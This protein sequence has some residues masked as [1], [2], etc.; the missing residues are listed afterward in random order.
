MT[1]EVGLGQ[2]VLSGARSPQEQA[3][4][5]SLD[6]LGLQV[7]RDNVL[8]VRNA[9]KTEFDRLRRLMAL[10]APMLRVGECGPDPVSGPAALLFNDK[11]QALTGQCTGYVEA[12]GDA[13][14]ALEQTARA[15]GYNEGQIV[16]SFTAFQAT[17][18]GELRGGPR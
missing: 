3:L 10:H 8:Q 1:G 13:A 18:H 12:L 2:R 11:V 17:E 7:N 14:D 16:A 4:A 5:G 6:A 9:L 15:Y